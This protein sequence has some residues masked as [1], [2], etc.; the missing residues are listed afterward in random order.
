M[1][2]WEDFEREAREVDK[3]TK[4]QS[5]DIVLLLQDAIGLFADAFS[6]ADNSDTTDATMAKMSLLS[7]NFA[8]LKCA[9]DLALRG[10]YSQSMN[11]LRIVYENWIAFHYLT[12]NPDEAHILLR[13]PNISNRLPD[14]AVMRKALGE[15]FNPLKEKIKQWYDVLC[16]FAHP[17]AAGVLPQITVNLISDETSIHY[18]TT[19]KDDFFRVSVY[20]ICIWTGVMLDAVGLWIPI[21]NEW[22]KRRNKLEERILRFIEEENEISKSKESKS[23]G[24]EQ[25]PTT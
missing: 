8:T 11:L 24:T 13:D 25:N 5:P 7:Q 2:T 12:K 15:D 1:N 9:V 16:C 22:Y 20:N 19:Y 17:H 6:I 18:G 3:L 10:Y 14:P 21:T 4:D 23:G